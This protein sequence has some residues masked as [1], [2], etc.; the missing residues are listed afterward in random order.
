MFFS[1]VRN[2]E[3]TTYNNR[4]NCEIAI[5]INLFNESVIGIENYERM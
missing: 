4:G 3:N 1:F 2:G 5:T